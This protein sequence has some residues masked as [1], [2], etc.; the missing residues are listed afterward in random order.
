MKTIEKVICCILSAAIFL[1]LMVWDYPQYK[2]K[3]MAEAIAGQ[4]IPFSEIL[5]DMG[6]IE[7]LE[8]QIAELD[9]QIAELEK[10]QKDAGTRVYLYFDQIY[11]SCYDQLFHLM[12][13]MGYTGTMV[14]TDGQ[15][16]GDRLQMT[17]DQ[18]KEMLDNGW[19][20]AIG[21]IEQ[22]DLTADLSEVK[23]QW[24]AYLTTYLSEIKQRLNVVP[25]TYCFNEGEYREEFDVILKEFGFQTIRYSAEEK[26]QKKDD[27]TRIRTYHVTQDTDISTA[28]NEL[29]T[30]SSVALCTRRVASEIGAG[31][32]NI[33]IEKYKELLE[34]IKETDGLIIADNAQI[35]EKQADKL[36]TDIQDLKK[37]R[38]DIL[39]KISELQK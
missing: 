33:E 6:N 16:P 37:Q 35:E 10:Q 8:K 20:L 7:E 5:G 30:D 15:L 11:E 1:Y 25:T 18:C 19:E 36:E 34:T 21:G 14:L 22:I 4:E 13:E 38:E 23:V 2:S 26:I 32:K 17:E 31:S 39:Q 9:A 24:K 27:M 12:K 28:V 29:K 3:L